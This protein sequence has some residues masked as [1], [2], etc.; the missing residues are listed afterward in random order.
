MADPLWTE[1]DAHARTLEL[2]AAFDR[3]PDVL[4]PDE[5]ALVMAIRE[6][7]RGGAD[8]IATTKNLIAGH[9]A[10]IADG[11]YRRDIKGRLALEDWT[12]FAESLRAE[13]I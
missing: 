6:L 4:S 13:A 8:L 2:L 3:N 7:E 11:H 9:I 12:R 1:A 10:A 5:Q